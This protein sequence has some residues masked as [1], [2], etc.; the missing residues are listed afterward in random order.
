[1]FTSN[2]IL[3]LGCI[4]LFISIS[5]ILLV[6]KIII[7]IV[8]G[9]NHVQRQRIF[10]DVAVSRNHH[11]CCFCNLAGNTRETDGV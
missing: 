2:D 9:A 11:I 7:D 8:K 1:M 4:Y 5:L 6:S 3:I 10:L